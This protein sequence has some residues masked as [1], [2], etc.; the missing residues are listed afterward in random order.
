MTIEEELQIR[1]E[2]ADFDRKIE[3]LQNLRQ[4]QIDKLA[5]IKAPSGVRDE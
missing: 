2:I 3:Q 4:F 5:Y 1:K